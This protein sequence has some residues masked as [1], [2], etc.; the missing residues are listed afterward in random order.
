[1]M[2]APWVR[3]E[4]DSVGQVLYMRQ[5]TAQE[6]HEQKPF[7]GVYS[8]QVVSPT[9]WHAMKSHSCWYRQQHYP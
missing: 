1:M 7:V 6:F 8:V 9:E 2:Y 4:V 3:S 5:E